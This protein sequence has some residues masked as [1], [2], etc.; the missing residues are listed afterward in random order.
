[1]NALLDQLNA[2]PPGDAVFDLD[3]TLLVGDIGESTLRRLIH[4]LPPRVASQLGTTNRWAAYEALAARDWC[5][6][7]DVAAQALAGLSPAE[8]SAIA[9]EV[10][11]SGDVRLN[12]HTVELARRIS[13]RHRVWILTGS[14][15]LLGKVAGARMGI[16]RVIGLRLRE[17]EGRLSDELLPPCTCGEGK[18]LAT[19]QL[20]SERPVFAIGDSPT[21]LPVLRLATIS[22][23]LG[24]IAGREFP[25]LET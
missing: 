4:R 20:I 25:A 2:L 14:A 12:P 18:V 1:M 13:Q 10:L 24:K 19:R 6:A 17:V 22:R 8:V 23:T 21:D 9:T 7:G 5:G 16:D 15:E 11:D 3:N